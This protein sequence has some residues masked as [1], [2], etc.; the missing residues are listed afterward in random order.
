MT[1]SR[2]A[3]MQ[4]FFS[5]SQSIAQD[6]FAPPPLVIDHRLESGVLA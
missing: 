4:P 6:R 5:K 1:S 2:Q 3:S